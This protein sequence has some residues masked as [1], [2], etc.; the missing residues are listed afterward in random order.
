MSDKNE[1][2]NNS[3]QR[4]LK[5]GDPMK[6]DVKNNLLEMIHSIQ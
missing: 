2:R 1:Q 6:N 3:Y 4:N 5:I